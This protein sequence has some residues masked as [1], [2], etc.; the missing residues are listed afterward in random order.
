VEKRYHSS[1][2]EKTDYR[3]VLNTLSYIHAN[4]EAAGIQRGLFYNLSNYGSYDRLSDDGLTEWHLA[5]LSLGESLNEC[6]EEYRKFC[7]RYRTQTKVRK[8]QL[9][10]Q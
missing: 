4:P 5:F 6:A 7:E 1:S 10:G 9:L 3:R 2:F 8:T